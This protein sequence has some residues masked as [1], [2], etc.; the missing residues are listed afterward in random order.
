VIDVGSRS[1]PLCVTDNEDN[2]WAVKTLG[3]LDLVSEPTP[4]TLGEDISIYPNPADDELFVQNTSEVPASIELYDEIGR[5]ILSVNTEASSTS[6]I[7]I[8]S[9]PNGDYFLVC[10]V[11]GRTVIK[12]ITKQ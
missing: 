5:E 12:N 4:L 3:V 2:H 6:T 9:L 7:D 11:G 1:I 10:H 8:A